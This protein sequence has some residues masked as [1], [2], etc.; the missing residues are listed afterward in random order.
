LDIK[1]IIISRKNISTNDIPPMIG[2]NLPDHINLI[3]LPLIDFKKIYSKEVKEALARILSSYYDYCIFLSSNSIDIFFEVIKDEE[4]SK[5]ILHKLS[6]MKIIVIGPKTKYALKKYGFDSYVADSHNNNY[7]I[8]GINNFL[9]SLESK[10]KMQEQRNTLRILIPRSAQSLKSGN[11]IKSNFENIELDQVF[12]Y[13]VT[14]SKDA[15]TSSEW[16]K[17][18]KVST[19]SGKTFLIFTSP[20]AVRSFF[21]IMYQL[22]PQLYYDKSEMEIIRSLKIYKVISIGPITSRALIDK[23]IDHIESSTHTIKG[24]LEVIFNFCSEY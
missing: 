6:K 16:K 15:F 11:L 20:S 17:M 19:Y 3:T 14:E 10:M 7:S 8:I 22:S 21:K 23:K 9:R 12:F 13:D 24:T 2:K 5:E 4:E 18:T 1:N